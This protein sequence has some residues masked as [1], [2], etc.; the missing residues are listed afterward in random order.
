MP[1][2]LRWFLFWTEKTAYG[3]SLSLNASDRREAHSTETYFTIEEAI[4]VPCWLVLAQ[5]DNYMK[6][7]LLISQMWTTV[8][9]NNLEWL[10]MV[11]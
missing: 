9:M 3:T 4:M 11:F 8:K 6:T 10:L 2:A 1:H 5:A 7:V